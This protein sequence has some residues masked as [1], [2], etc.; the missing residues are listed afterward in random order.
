MKIFAGIITP[1]TGLPENKKIKIFKN[2]T[3]PFSVSDEKFN[4]S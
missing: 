4:K 3:F 2:Q 1:S